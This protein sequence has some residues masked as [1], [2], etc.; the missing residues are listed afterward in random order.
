LKTYRLN[1]LSQVIISD[2]KRQVAFLHQ[3]LRLQIFACEL[4]F[5]LAAFGENLMRYFRF[6]YVALFAVAL[7]SAGYAQETQTRVVDEVVAQVNEGVITLS[8]IK[9][10]SKAIVDTY[11]QEGKTLAEAQKIVDEKQGELIASLINEELLIQRAKELGLDKDIEESLNARM[12]DIMKQ[13]NLKTVEALYAEMEKQGVDPRD[14]REN[15]RKQAIRERVINREVQV[16]IYWKPNGKE[17]K[18]YF[19]KNKSKFLKPETVSI[20]ELFLS[21]AGRDEAAVR[22][23]AKQLHTQLKAGADFAK[24]VKENGDPGAVTEGAGKAEKIIVS[25]LVDK[26]GVPLKGVKVGDVTAPIEIEQLGITI[27]KVDERELATGESVFDENA[28]RMAITQERAPDE[29]KKFMAK[30]RTESYIKISDQYRPIVSPIL[31]A[32]ERQEKPGK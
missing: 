24:L 21:F 18:D 25:Q 6:Y 13:Y 3:T 17:L 19:E 22:E 31:F 27:L 29:Q 1:G 14:I 12:L 16:V 9:R 11:V 8:R 28:I 30:L 5:L 20:S 32:D 7:S 2:K 10:E 26:I 4:R 15:W 23:K